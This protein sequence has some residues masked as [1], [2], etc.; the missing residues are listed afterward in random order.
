MRPALLVIDVQEDFLNRDITPS[1]L[2]LMNHIDH[3]ISHCRI[4]NVPIYFV[5]TAEGGTPAIIS[6][7]GDRVYG[8]EY[9][10]AFDVEGVSTVLNPEKYP[11]GFDTVIIAG[12]YTQV[13]IQT[14]A[15]AA[16]ARGL[17]VIVAADCVASYD[18]EHAMLSLNWMRDK[19]AKLLSNTEII[20]MIEG[21]IEMRDLL[22]KFAHAVG[23]NMDKIAH[24]MSLDIGKIVPDSE[25]EIRL[26]I[27]YI[28][29]AI[30]IS[31]L[32]TKGKIEEGVNVR[33]IPVGNIGIITPWN[34][35]VSI[36]LSKIAIAVALGN[37]VVW[38][39]SEKAHKTSRRLYDIMMSTG[40][41]RYVKAEYGDKETA[42]KIINDDTVDAISFTGSSEAGAQVD[43]LCY[44]LAKP[45]QAEMGGNNADIIMDDGGDLK[46]IAHRVICSA[47]AF[48]GQKCTATR[49]I[50][51][52]ESIADDFIK[53]FCGMVHDWGKLK[54]INEEHKESILTK[55]EIAIDAGANLIA[56]KQTIL[57]TANR[58]T[59]VVLETDDH[60]LE[61]VQEETFGP[62]VVI[63]R[64]KDIS[65]ALRLCNCV[66]QGLMATIYSQDKDEIDQF[67][68]EAEVGMM[69][70]NPYD[71]AIHPEAPFVGT[72]ESWIGPPEHGVW[73]LQFYSRVQTIYGDLCIT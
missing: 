64:A 70:I 33:H 31:K 12:L 27:E 69:R 45:L 21:T 8:K 66:C 28:E 51:L 49:R 23:E 63:M 58:M 15:I 54:V 71:F 9:Y 68:K 37:T 3:L 61:I 17:N 62:V 39:P 67:M 36:P 5:Q 11:K 53:L 40:L 38:K 6:Q 29:T 47:F 41:S 46:K 16:A 65:H 14:T 48:S 18:K 4:Y 7:P 22:Q 10:N 44:N 59:P 56:G 57:K 25:D 73:D 24:D 13:C 20:K 55:V 42:H 60:M 43:S 1:R 35:P 34:N 72:K 52:H 2:Y 50:I 19:V 26:A 30:T 32:H